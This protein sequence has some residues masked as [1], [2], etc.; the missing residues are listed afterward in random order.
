MPDPVT[1]ASP[2]ELAQAIQD[3]L[4]YSIG[5][6]EAH[7]SVHDWR[8]ALSLAIRDNIVQPWFAST[9]AT[10]DRALES[11]DAVNSEIGALIQSTWGR[12]PGKSP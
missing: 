7:A 5:K 8:V 11:L 6:D 2:K 9:R 10:Y 1:S 3:H 12:K 4:T